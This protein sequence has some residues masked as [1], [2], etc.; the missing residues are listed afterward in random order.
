MTRSLTTCKPLLPVHPGSGI[1]DTWWE[2]RVPVLITSTS[3]VEKVAIGDMH[4]VV[5]TK[6]GELILWRT[7]SPERTSV[8]P[9]LIPRAKWSLWMSHE[10]NT[11]QSRNEWE[12]WWAQVLDKAGQVEETVTDDSDEETILRILGRQKIVDVALGANFVLVLRANGE[13]WCRR[14][15]FLQ[16]HQ[17]R[18]RVW[19]FVS[20]PSPPTVP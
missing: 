11:G 20:W 7:D 17:E 4:A 2:P 16:E 18:D 8:L 3:T 1:Q 19:H 10:H 5:L 12:E 6:A 9:G 14:V 13:V 15:E